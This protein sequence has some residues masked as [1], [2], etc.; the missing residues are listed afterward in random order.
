MSSNPIIDTIKSGIHAVTTAASGLAS[1]HKEQ[2]ENQQ[3]TEADAGGVFNMADENT[4]P[5]STEAP[6]QSR[7]AEGSAEAPGPR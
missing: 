1:A 7:A 3:S 6:S 2:T 5:A 4:K